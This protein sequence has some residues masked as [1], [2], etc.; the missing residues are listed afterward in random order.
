MN[1]FQKDW[2][3]FYTDDPH[4][5]L[6]EWEKVPSEGRPLDRVSIPQMNAGTLYYVIVDKPKEGIQT[7]MF[8]VM[9][10]SKHTSFHQSTGYTSQS[11]P[12]SSS[13]DIL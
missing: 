1:I 8:S 10:P 7:P 12:C 2:T 5:N 11:T 9:T 3:I 4:Q 6:D 13:L